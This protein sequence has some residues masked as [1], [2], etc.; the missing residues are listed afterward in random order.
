LIG[1]LLIAIEVFWSYERFAA[2][3]KWTTMVLL[4]YVVSGIVVGPPW[5]T[6]LR[7][8]FVPRLS[9]DRTTLAAVVALLGTTISPYMFFWIS[10]EEVE[11]EHQH[12]D[13]RS[14]PAKRKERRR[15]VV[16]GMAYANV[17]FF[18][19]V[20]ANAATLGQHHTKIESAAAAAKALG[21]IVGHYAT[22]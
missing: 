12:R 19:I 8:T 18:F 20:L 11:E 15:D 17:I 9:F 21:P 13:R 5:A 14:E 16:F 1:A 2:I 6:V 10:S 4:L 3:I 22:V 7:H